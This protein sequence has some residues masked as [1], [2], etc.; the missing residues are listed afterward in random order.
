MMACRHLAAAAALGLVLNGSA[1][2]ALSAVD[3]QGQFWSINT[4]TGTPTG[5]GTTGFGRLNSLAMN[6]SGVLYTATDNSNVVVGPDRLLSIDP[7]TGMGTSVAILN[8]GAVDPDVRSMAFRPSDGA[9][10]VINAGGSGG[11]LI[12]S[13]FRVDPGTGAGTFIAALGSVGLQGLDFAAD[14]TLYAWSNPLGLVTLNANTGALADVNPGVVG[15]VMQSIVFDTDGRLYGAA[16]SG[17]YSIDRNT[18]VQTL[19]GSVGGLDIRGIEAMAPIP[20]PA[21]MLLMAAGVA[22]LGLR[23]RRAQAA[24]Q[25]GAA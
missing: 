20:E 10:F 13:L 14:G 22:L 9:L 25:G 15:N 1:L 16:T 4:S 18:G 8:F 23:R 21:S 7:A 6:N 19:I 24:T 5:A 11:T 2:A 3:F 17:F 12:N